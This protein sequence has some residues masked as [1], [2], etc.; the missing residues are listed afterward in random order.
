MVL[1]D[2]NIVKDILVTNGAIFSSRKEMFL[3]VQT[4]LVH[5]GITASGYNET[6]YVSRPLTRLLRPLTLDWTE[7]RRKH[8]RIAAKIL[9]SRAVSTYGPAIEFEAREM[10]RTL[11]VDGMAGATAINPQPYASRFALNNILMAIYGI[12]TESMSDPVVTEVLRISREFMYVYVDGARSI[13][14]PSLSHN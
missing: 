6:W 12:R 9:T 10:I 4:I 8:R 5:R 13:R 3:K 1:S 14:F 2:P 11:L 7:Y